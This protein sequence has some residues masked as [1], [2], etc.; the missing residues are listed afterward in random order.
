[1]NFEP[2]SEQELEEAMLLPDGDY[3]FEVSNAEDKTS[4]GGNEMIAIQ[5]TV[6]DEQGRGTF[7]RDWLVAKDEP[8]CL[9][10]ILQFCYAT[11]LGDQYQSGNLTSDSCYGATGR[12]TVRQ[13]TSTDYGT[14]NVVSGYLKPGSD[15]TNQ[16]RNEEDDPV[17][18]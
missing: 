6:F 8:L 9:Q 15:S 2:K 11:G 10:K 18:F 16:E 3:P 7:L 5:L 1:M 13:R 4:K 14:Q 17:P 12:C